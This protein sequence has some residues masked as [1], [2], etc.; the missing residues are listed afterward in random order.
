MKVKQK[1]GVKQKLGSTMEESEEKTY[2][3][4]RWNS[5]LEKELFVMGLKSQLNF[6]TWKFGKK[7]AT[8]KDKQSVFFRKVLPFYNTKMNSAAPNLVVANVR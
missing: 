2:W 5:F 7:E 4:E 1:V 6:I 8:R 3:F